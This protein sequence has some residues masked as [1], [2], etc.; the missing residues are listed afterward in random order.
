VRNSS[1][2]SHTLLKNILSGEILDPYPSA[3]LHKRCYKTGAGVLKMT[4][5]VQDVWL[6]EFGELGEET[7]HKRLGAHIW[8]EDKERLARQWLELRETSLAREANDL[9]RRANDVA[10]EANDIARRANDIARSN[11]FIAGLA[12]FGA[13]IAIAI[14]IIGL[15]LKRG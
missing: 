13:A 3:S 2:S 1:T 10:K 12:L 7:V 5:D 8:G 14:S 11:N 4:D 6:K 15:F 9:A